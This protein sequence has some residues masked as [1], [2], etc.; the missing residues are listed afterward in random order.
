MKSCYNYAWLDRSPLH[1][2]NLNQTYDIQGS[3]HNLLKE[4]SLSSPLAFYFSFSCS[5]SSIIINY[6][7]IWRYAALIAKKISH[8]HWQI[9]PTNPNINVFKVLNISPMFIL[10]MYFR[11]SGGVVICPMSFRDTHTESN[12]CS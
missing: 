4:N 6:F 9:I 10:F 7:C 8:K 5:S 11:D 2:W 3:L 12:T 1:L